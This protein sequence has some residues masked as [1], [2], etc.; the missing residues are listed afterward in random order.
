MMKKLLYIGM[1]GLSLGAC[2]DNDDPVPP[3]TVNLVEQVTTLTTTAPEDSEPVDIAALAATES[4]TD[5]PVAVT[6]P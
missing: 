5:E 3:P 4:E 2:S 1:L 6:F